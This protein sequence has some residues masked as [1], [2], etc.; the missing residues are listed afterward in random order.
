MKKIPIRGKYGQGRH[1]LIDNDDFA[2]VSRYKWHSDRNGYAVRTTSFWIEG[3]KKH[4]HIY[5]HRELI[6]APPG[7]IVDHINRNKVD[8]RKDNLRFCT[9]SQSNC[10][11]KRKNKSGYKGVR[12]T[13][14]GWA[15][16]IDSDGQRIYVGHYQDLKKAVSAYNS[17][18]EKHHGEFA[19][20]NPL[21]S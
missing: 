3:A 9:I 20:L 16:E 1:A 12:P 6:C 14:S 2:H 5:M 15:V 7:Q 18:A 10:N 11:L 4:Q 19:Y 21:P 13:R 8:N 17:A